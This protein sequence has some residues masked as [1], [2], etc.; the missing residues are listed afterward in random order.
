M[1][2]KPAIY[3]MPPGANF[4]ALLVAGLR[5]QMADQPPEAM[6]DV[7]L[8]VNTARMRRRVVDLFVAAGPGLLPRI[9]LVTDL[10]AQT[11]LP[12]LPPAIPPLRRRLELSVLIGRLLEREADLAPRSALFDLSD[13]LARLMEEMRGEGVD[14]ATIANLDVSE[15][16][17]HWKR[18]QDFMAIAA[19]YFEAASPPDAE[20]RQRA[21][22]MS[23]ADRWQAAPPAHPVILAGSTGSRGTTALLMQAVARLPR[24]MVVLP[25][26]DFDLPKAVWRALDGTMVAEDHPQFRFHRLLQALD[27]GPE[28]VRRWE[29]ASAPA[30]DRNH[31]IS[32]SLRPAPVTDQWLSEGQDLP[33]LPMATRDVTL[34]E[35]PSPRMEALAIALILRNAADGGHRAALVTPD[36]GLSRQV[37]AALDRWGIVPDD[38]AGRP[39]ALS[40]PGRFLRH[41]A[42]LFG[43]K[44][45]TEALLTLL[46]HPLCASG[47]EGR[48]NHLRLT[49]ELELWLRRRG[50]PF[51]DAKVMTDWAGGQ[52]DAMA[53]DWAEWLVAT[54]DKA[55]D[56][57]SLPLQDHVERHLGIAE[58]LVAGRGGRGDDGKPWGSN[59]WQGKAGA[60]ARIMAESLLAEA[61]HGGIL[62]PADYLGL[63]EAII[64]K[65]EVR[66]D[67]QSHPRIMI[68]GT[69]EAR[70][71]GADLV[72]LGGLNDGIWPQL[73]P[74]DPWMNRKMRHEAGLLL[75]DRQIG[76]SAHD[77]QQAVAATTVVLTRAVRDA[78]AETVPSRWLNRLTNLMGG[79]PLRG[80]PLALADMR[81]RG[82]YWL[83]LAER[84]GQAAAEPAKARRVA[85]CPPMTARP[86]ELPVT[87]IKMLIR[88]PYTIYARYVLRLRKLDPLH[89]QADAMLRG[90]VLHRIL[91][92]FVRERGDE[93]REQA[94]VRL[95]ELT[96]EVLQDE[97]P[98]AAAR[99][100][101]QSRLDRAADFFLYH[102]SADGGAPVILEKE[103]RLPLYPL[104]FTLKGRPDRIDTLPDGR[105]HIVDYKT[106]APPSK[107]EQRHFDKQLL[108]LAAMAER[109][110]FPDLG[111]VEVAKVSYLGLG[112]KPDVV[113]TDMTPQLMAEVWEGF[114]RLVASYQSSEKGYSPRRAMQKDTDASDYDHLSRFG[115]WDMTELPEV[116]KVGQ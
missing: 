56:A 106:G 116:Q 9:R 103:G 1:N 102:D 57:R 77:Y 68:W 101:W 99:V 21:V 47:G 27:L 4:P 112:T 14:P 113:S 31:L 23:M 87:A 81:A 20:A 67:V 8:I 11:P 35:A 98:W 59:L 48:G 2:G 6:A 3:A 34:I 104:D 54:L 91:E 24:G 19:R 12:G 43:R 89:P 17:A 10:G 15:H 50:A 30:P 85:P 110:G 33:D 93:T 41:I 73:P 53:P 40:A 46:K 29:G 61:A 108:L 92:R 79:L 111:P 88:D 55:D 42:G 75:P 52:R 78:E 5:R 86:R 105:L 13:S 25:G 60:E 39:L 114:N 22:V 32:L 26:F 74:A 16:S 49:R 94:R 83:S 66:E 36:R 84:L 80:G 107:A 82:N 65:G 115:E 44:T 38:S 45:T 37:T 18:T 71:Q 51:P 96:H 58:T 64:A 28:D 97:V 63:F 62:S 72:I 7:D 109:G 95:A 69:L 90:Q 76:L 70:V 100:F